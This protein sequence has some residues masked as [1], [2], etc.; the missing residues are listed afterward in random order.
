M[1]VKYYSTFVPELGGV[2]FFPSEPKLS[3]ILTCVEMELLGVRIT[4]LATCSVAVA[5][6][7]AET[8]FTADLTI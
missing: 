6:C 3:G 7:I 1:L 4:V 2:G 5:I 8:S